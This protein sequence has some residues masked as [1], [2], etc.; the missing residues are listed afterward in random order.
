M[1]HPLPIGG[2]PNP[3][4]V[5]QF[6]VQRFVLIFGYRREPNACC[7]EATCQPLTPN[8]HHGA[9]PALDAGGDRPRPQYG[10]HAHR[11]I[12]YTVPKWFLQACPMMV[13]PLSSIGGRLVGA[14]GDY[15]RRGTVRFVRY[16]GKLILTLRFSRP[17][18]QRPLLA[19]GWRAPND[20]LLP[21]HWRPSAGVL[22]GERR[23]FVPCS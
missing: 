18:P 7:A 13:A 5:T 4:T 22:D 17:D 21:V 3:P 8:L 9:I 20:P 14:R 15:S 12:I 11:R 19:K 10:V 23:W 16:T 2:S 6:I 1:S